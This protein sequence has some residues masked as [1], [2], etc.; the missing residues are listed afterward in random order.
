MS[1]HFFILL[2][3]LYHWHANTQ[4]ISNIN[5]DEIES[6]VS[7]STS[8]FFYPLLVDRILAMDTTLS[9]KDYQYLYYGNVFQEYYYPYGATEKQK[10]FF[11][12][13]KKEDSFPESE[14][15][16]LE[17]LNENPVNLEVLLS[18]IILYNAEKNVDKATEFSRVYVSF[19]EVIYQ[20]GIGKSCEDAFVVISVDDEYRITG[21]LG[22]KVVRQDLIGS[23]DRLVFFKKGTKTPG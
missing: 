6:A 8:S 19:L 3:G 11:E 16:G 23:C 13:I 15:L 1:R 17:V 9:F 10:R 12:S 21:D 22:L 18:M 2:L 7:D 5:F 4:A 20:S 14:Q